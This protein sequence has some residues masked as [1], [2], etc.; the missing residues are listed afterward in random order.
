MSEKVSKLV[1]VASPLRGDYDRNMELARQYCKHVI[2]NGF[3][4]YAP[5]LLFTQF[6]DDTIP[7]ERATGMAMG[8]EMLKRCDELWVFGETI[9]EGMAAEIELAKELDI[10]IH[11][12]KETATREAPVMKQAQE[13][14]NIGPIYIELPGNIQQKLINRITRQILNDPKVNRARFEWFNEVCKTCKKRGH[15]KAHKAPVSTCPKKKGVQ[16]GQD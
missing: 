10:P 11:Y 2:D 4:P 9:S 1:Y 7:E 13:A 5:H 6:M 12:I 14:I 16:Y 15:C 8:I 3:I